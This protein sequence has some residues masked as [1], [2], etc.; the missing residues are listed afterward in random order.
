[1]EQ[2]G[3]VAISADIERISKERTTI[4]AKERTD[5]GLSDQD[6]QRLK[7]IERELDEAYDA[8]RRERAVHTARRFDHESNLLR[9]RIPHPFRP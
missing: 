3:A 9:G 4:F 5:A 1:M 2:S 6:R 8:L 7:A